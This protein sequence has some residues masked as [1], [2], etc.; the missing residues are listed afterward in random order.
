MY[1]SLPRRCG[2]GAVSNNGR[3]A[4]LSLGV[5]DHESVVVIVGGGFGGLAAAKALKNAVSSVVLIARTNHHLFQPLLYQGHLGADAQSDRLPHPRHSSRAGEHH[6]LLGEITGVD[7]ANRCVLVSDA[8]RPDV[9][10]P[11]EYLI[12]RRELAPTYFRPR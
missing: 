3:A 11:Y 5:G 8:D 10:V 2:V 9:R 1:R 7:Q 6:R 4:S 12:W